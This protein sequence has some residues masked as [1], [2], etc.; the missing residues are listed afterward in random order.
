LRN[1]VSSSG[2]PTLSFL[3]GRGLDFYSHS[4]A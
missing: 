3:E 1:W 4:K 2:W